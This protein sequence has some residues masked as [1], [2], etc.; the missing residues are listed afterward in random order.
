MPAS[1]QSR[2][3]L[4]GWRG[5]GRFWV[6]VL[7]AFWIGV[8]VLQVL[9]PPPEPPGLSTAGRP[10]THADPLPVPQAPPAAAVREAF[11]FTPAPGQSAPGQPGRGLPGPIADPEPAL[12]EALA[13]S[14]QAM[15]PRI[16]ADGRT[17]MSTYA[18]GFD[19]SSLR[20]RVGLLIAGIGMSEAE[21]LNAIKT[22]PAGV[23][24][25]ISA[26]AANIGPLLDVA[27]INGHEY[28]L[29][30]PME[31]VGFP[32]NDPDD[33]FALMTALPPEEN[34]KRLRTLLTRMT[35]Y[36]GVTDAL[37]QMHGE[38]L[39]GVPDQLDSVLEEIAHRGLLFLDA[40]VSQHLLT[41]AWNRP[42]DLLIDDDRVDAAALDQRLDALTRMALDKGSAL[43]IV[44]VPRPV[45]VERIAA[46]ANTLQSKGLALAPVSALVLPPAKQ[47]SDQ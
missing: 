27:R 29:S 41:H 37:G 38:R 42:A 1:Q 34:L 23:T 46:W 5:L 13:G 26:Y 18:A 47:E 7:V 17:P 9:G 21:S 39:A 11:K 8:G 36:V 40:R 25:G 45:T 2:G 32:A 22:L 4:A 15:L 20:P 6:A 30:V 44:S 33:R 24:L 12:L 3:L 28:L 31:P 10:V 19:P 16:A 43:G 35:G 14:P